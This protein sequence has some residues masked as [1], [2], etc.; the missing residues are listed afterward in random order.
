MDGGR[1]DRF[2]TLSRLTGLFGK[3]DDD[4]NEAVVAA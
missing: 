3:V 2:P 1:S 4:A